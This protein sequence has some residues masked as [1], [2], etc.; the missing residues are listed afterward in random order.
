MR[1]I[2]YFLL[3]ST[4]AFGCKLENKPSQSSRPYVILISFDGYRYDYARKHDAKNLLSYV[5]DGVEAEGLIP[6]Y[7]SKT[8]P[9]H[10]TIVTGLYPDNHGLVSNVFYNKSRGQMYTPGNRSM[11][12]DGSWYGGTPIWN[13]AEQNGVKAASYFWIGSEANIQNSRPSYYRVYDGSIPH[14]DRIN[15]VIEWLKLPENE[16]PHL[17]TMY[18]SISDDYGHRDGPESE[19]IGEVVKILDDDL[20]VLVDGV[21]ELGLPVNY[22]LVSDHGMA[23]LDTENPIYL[24]DY[25]NTGEF[26]VAP[27]DELLMFY[28]NDQTYIDS[29]YNII[30]PLAKRFRIFKKQEIPEYLNYG[31]NENVGDLLLIP[32]APYVFANSGDNS[33]HDAHGF[34]PYNQ[35]THGFDPYQVTDMQGIFY[36][37]GPGI[38]NG[39]KIPPFQ[40]IHIFPFIADLLNLPY[41]SLQLDSNPEVLKG[42]LKN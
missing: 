38:Q 17:I 2:L 16:R 19:S 11:V 15:Q 18:F 12:E 41:D 7:P 36:A 24:D 6:S 40:N 8:F 42:V 22:I 35:G 10:Y 26:T 34:D 21:G 23:Q 20:K 14:S 27:S 25:I 37:W 3:I 29:V 5:E 9:N 1:V 33:D 30:Y 31:K 13:L 4:L 39:L 32:D 28:H